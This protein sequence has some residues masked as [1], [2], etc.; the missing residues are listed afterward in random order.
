MSVLITNI[1]R[2]SFHDGQ[3]IRTTVFFKGCTLRCPWCANP[4]NIHSEKEYYCDYGFCITKKENCIF[5]E[6]YPILQQEKN[7]ICCPTGRTKVFGEDY[8]NDTLY[9]ELTKDKIYFLE[10]DGGIT[11]SGGE[12]FKQLYKIESVLKKLKKDKLHLA[13]ETSLFVSDKYLEP[14]IP[15]IDFFYI[16]IKSLEPEIVS[17]ILKGN[18]AN[19]IN[20]LK[21]VFSY[22]KSV[23]FRIPLVP[24]ITAT[25]NNFNLL[26]PFLMKYT[27]LGIEY[28]SVHNLAEKKYKILNKKNRL[29][30]QADVVDKLR[31]E[32]ICKKL[33]IPC[34][35]LI[36]V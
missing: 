14:I 4:E 21:I 34:K 11:F 8:D 18:L 9:K 32:A 22:R 36:V 6:N 12:P 20:N 23:V 10:T 29:F 30:K 25:E 5:S 31:I 3:G 2:S 7:G 33:S 15:Y 16:D 35:E 1:Q 24:N 19:Y 13:V 17:S 28:F 26:E 27:P